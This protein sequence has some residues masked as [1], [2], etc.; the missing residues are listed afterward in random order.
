MGVTLLRK[1]VLRSKME[2]RIRPVTRKDLKNTLSERSQTKN[3]MVISFLSVVLNGG[4]ITFPQPSRG[5]L[6]M[7]RNIFPCHIWQREG[8]ARGILKTEHMLRHG[9][10]HMPGPHD[11][12]CSSPKWQECQG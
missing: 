12:E 3:K 10:E 6:G 9:V 1:N 5:H 7:S 2:L 4:A 11:K 8:S